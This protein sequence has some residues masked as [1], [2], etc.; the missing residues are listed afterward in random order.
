VDMEAEYDNRARVP[1]HPAIIAGWSRDAAAFR[2][3]G[4]ASLDLAYGSSAR[5]RLDVFLP[6]DTPVATAMFIHGGYWQAFDKSSFSHLARGLVAHRIAVAIPS[7][8]LCPAVRL[9]AI[10]D[11]MGEACDWLAPRFG[12]PVSVIGHSA[13]GHLAACLLAAGRAASSAVAAVVSAY[14]IS[15]LFDLQPLI[16]TPVNAKVK[17]TPS[18]A[19]ALSPIFWQAPAGK[20]LVAAVGALE[21]SEYHRQSASLCEVW[22]RAGARARCE[23]VDGANHFTIVAPLADPASPMTRDVVALIRQSAAP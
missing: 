18:E 15:G 16:H 7:Y 11:Q 23:V 19:R 14:A 13:G 3:E 2:A 20:A 1:E 8:D 5:S 17:L 10:V 9:G 22:G 12:P 6:Q 21:S 4:K